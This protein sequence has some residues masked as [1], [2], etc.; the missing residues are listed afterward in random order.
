[1][2]EGAVMKSLYCFLTSWLLFN[3]V[4][5][6]QIP[7][8][9]FE[10]WTGGDP[11]GWLTTN[12]PG[13]VNSVTQSSTAHSGSSA[14]RGEVVLV[15]NKPY[16]P[17]LQSGDDGDGFP[18]SQRYAALTGYHIF[19]PVGGDRF[20]V[21]VVM[22]RNSTGIGG[23]YFIDSTAKSS[24]TQFTVP[25][26]YVNPGTPDTCIVTILISGPQGSD[27]HVGSMMLVDDL[28]FGTT[29]AVDENTGITPTQFSLQQNYPNPFNPS[30]TITYQ[31]PTSSFISLKV[32]NVLGNEIT[33]LV[34]EEKK[35]GSYK[36]TWDAGGITSGVYFY[37]LH[38]RPTDGHSAQF[39]ET[40]KLLLLR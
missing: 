32:Y 38:A 13:I 10:R 7:N 22:S 23:G 5:S 9:G 2:H 25:I 30:T 11:E 20:V 36:L 34:N 15:S 16:G 8:G 33:T 14:A 26:Q 27:Y 18:V 35:S 6:A 21:G 17:L 19:R 4:A 39:V 12:V 24:Y 29:T 31:I 40:R 28:A 37:R 1:M 3:V